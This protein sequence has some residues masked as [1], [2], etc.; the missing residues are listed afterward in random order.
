MPVSAI[1]IVRRVISVAS[2]FRRRTPYNDMNSG[3]TLNALSRSSFFALFY[4]RPGVIPVRSLYLVT[5]IRSIV[6]PNGVS[7]TRV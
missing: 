5:M 6:R 1:G 2:A 7:I 3:T 4:G